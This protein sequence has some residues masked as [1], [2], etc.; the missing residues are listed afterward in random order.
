[1]AAYHSP[2]RVCSRLYRIRL[3]GLVCPIRNVLKLHQRFF[4]PGKRLRA[5]RIHSRIQK[6]QPHLSFLLRSWFAD[7]Y[8]VALRSIHWVFVWDDFDNLSAF[9]SE[10]PHESE[11]FCRAIDYE[12][13]K[14]FRD[15]FKIDDKTGT[16][17]QDNPL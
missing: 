5:P 3:V 14:P 12:A 10:S 6:L 17:F 15:S 13:G 7:P 8:H 4:L 2:V 11:P 9:Q 16:F 1:M